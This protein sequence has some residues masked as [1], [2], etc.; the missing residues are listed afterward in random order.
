MA[1]VFPHL[2]EIQRAEDERFE[3]QFVCK[4][5]RKSSCHERLAKA[6]HVGKQDAAALLYMVCSYL[7]GLFL[8][9]K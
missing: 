3:K 7:D 2:D 4:N 1:V 8:K 9:L 6:D 5:S